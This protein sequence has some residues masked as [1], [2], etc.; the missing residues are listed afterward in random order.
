MSDKAQPSDKKIQSVKVGVNLL[1]INLT[2][3]Y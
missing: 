3:L 2:F 1:F